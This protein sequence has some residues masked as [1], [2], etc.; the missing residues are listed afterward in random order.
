MQGIDRHRQS[1]RIT[2]PLVLRLFLGMVLLIAFAVGSAVFVTYV[3]GRQIAQHAV[4]KALDTS[5]AV[6][7]E[8]EQRRL[9]QLQLAVRLLAADANFIKYIA[10]ASGYGGL[11][12]LGGADDAPDTGSMRDLLIERQQD[13]GIDLAILLDADA[14]LLARTDE[15][16][17]FAASMATDPLVEPALRDGTPIS[18][19][20]RQGDQLFQAAIMPLARDQDLV[21]FLVVALT[22]SDQLSQSVAKV[23]SAEIAFWLPAEDDALLIA[24]SL[25]PAAAQELSRLVEQ[26]HSEFLPAIQNGTMIDHIPM[27]FSGQEWSARLVPAAAPGVGRLGS[28][29]IMSSTEQITASYRAILN[30][31]VLAGL[32]SLG[33]AILLSV[34][35]ARRILRPI[36]TM[37]AAAEAAAAGDYQ[38]RIGSEGSDALGRLATAFDSLLSDLREKKDIEGYVGQMARF[39]PEP[40]AEPAVAPV[41]STPRM[42]PQ[43]ENLALLE[44]EFRHLLASVDAQADPVQRA[45]AHAGVHD[46]LDAIASGLDI[47]VRAMDGARWRLAC[48]GANRLQTAVKAWATIL[49]DCSQSG[50]AA[51]AGALTDGAIV[52]AIGMTGRPDQSITLGTPVAHGDRLLCDAAPGQL[53]FTRASGEILKPTLADGALS[54]VTGGFSGKKFYALSA[55]SL[56]AP[57]TPIK[58]TV[59]QQTATTT[60]A[61]SARKVPASGSIAAGSVLGGRYRIITQLGEGGMGIVY[62]AHDLELD[63]IVA[64]KMLRPGLLLDTEQVDRLKSEIKLARRI[65]HPNVLR[66]FDFGDVDGRPC[67]S[68]EYVRGLTLRYL[69]SETKRVPY[70]A[71]LRIARQLAAGLAAAHEVGVLHRDIKP[72]NLILEANGNAKL[73]D[74]G[75]A[76]PLRRSTPGHTQA[77]TFVGTPDYCS[78]EQLSG[79]DIDERADIYACGVL[80]SEMFC[81]GMPY[82]GANTMDIYQAQ[83]SDTPRR[84]SELW[85]DIPAD[86]EAIIL[87]C[88]RSAREER[89]ASAVDL[90]QA[91]SGLRS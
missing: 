74:F 42:P 39:L 5:T 38:T 66:T 10:D 73:M 8:F 91:L 34:F 3:Q 45:Q 60:S 58:S 85:A 76:R 48:A 21:G 25:D 53:L 14:N 63:D 72:E 84:P 15:L 30:R 13:F 4:D 1:G 24:S 26:R 87:R 78:P 61:T 49:R 23:S 86:L 6:Q 28:V 77:G 51:P 33:I 35:L 17:S 69:L 36:G 65:T 11:P 43:R 59:V 46:L 22:V 68:M 7:R 40:G 19:Y 71:A 70:S 18:G 82:A 16:E 83:I 67:I 88:V 79:G 62:K 54:V 81:G 41:A 27:R 52:R 9:D 37:A 56:P 75:I 29:A 80:M 44:V 12:G 2:M 47:E 64:L 90:G 20:W 32:I 89:F 31:V 50:L 55:A 57:G